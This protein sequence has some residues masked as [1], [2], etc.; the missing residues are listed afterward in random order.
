MQHSGG[1]VRALCLGAERS[2]EVFQKSRSNVCALLPM[3]LDID[4]YSSIVSFSTFCRTASTLR[5]AAAA[6]SMTVAPLACGVRKVALQTISTSMVVSVVATRRAKLV[7][8][9][10][11]GGGHAGEN[12]VRIGPR[13]V[14]AQVGHPNDELRDKRG[15]NGQ[16][17]PRN[18]L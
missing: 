14:W 8:L 16:R 12:G 4:E 15:L 13:A 2:G 7:A 6:A 11:A 5:T 3:V 10:V 9:V 1:A 17:E 18:P